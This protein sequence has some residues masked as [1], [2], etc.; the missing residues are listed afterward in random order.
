M[1]ACKVVDITKLSRYKQ[2]LLLKSI[3]IKTLTMTNAIQ[4]L[5]S[6]LAL[7][8]SAFI[9]SLFAACDNADD[10]NIKTINTAGGSSVIIANNTALISGYGS[11]NNEVTSRFWKDTDK[12]DEDNFDS[13][14]PNQTL[15]RKAIDEDYLINYVYKDAQGQ[16]QYYQFDQGSLAEN[17]RVFYYKNGVLT[18]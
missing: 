15:Y 10:D 6:R 9:I 7:Y 18:F 4:L 5:K 11:K 17:G 14:I 3:L 12:V 16:N 8:F 1:K 2:P 13:N